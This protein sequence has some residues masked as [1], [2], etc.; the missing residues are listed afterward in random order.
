MDTRGK[1]RAKPFSGLWPA[2]DTLK[3]AKSANRA[4]FWATIFWASMRLILVLLGVLGIQFVEEV[5]LWGLF[6]VGLFGLIAWGLWKRSR[7]A[8]IAGPVLYIGLIILQWI[9][10]GPPTWDLRIISVIITFLFINGIRGTFAYR[11]LG[12]LVPRKERAES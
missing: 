11:R 5:N 7:I 3:G 9:D 8:A 6:D 12:G 4:A 10:I 1:V 2:V